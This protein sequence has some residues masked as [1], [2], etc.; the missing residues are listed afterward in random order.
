MNR[1]EAANVNTLL[2]WLLEFSDD[3]AELPSCERA[4][5]AAAELAESALV[6]SGTGICG[7]EVREAWHWADDGYDEDV[8]YVPVETIT[9]AGER[10]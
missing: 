4:R 1:D 3:E 6:A 7:D 2:V 9:V 8:R 10:L 5:D